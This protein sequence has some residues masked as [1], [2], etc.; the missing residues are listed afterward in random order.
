M[1]TNNWL[2][3]LRAAAMDAMA[4]AAASNP[5]RTKG[6]GGDHPGTHPPELCGAWTFHDS[7]SAYNGGYSSSEIG[8][9]LS[10]DSSCAFGSERCWPNAWP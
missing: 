6:G 3:A 2:D 5:C 9:T 7:A 4:A 10:R 1:N 8:F